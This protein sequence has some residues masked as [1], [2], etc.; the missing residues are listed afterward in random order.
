MFFFL[1]ASFRIRQSSFL[2]GKFDL[3]DES[4]V[5]V[6]LWETE[7]VGIDGDEVEMLESLVRHHVCL[8][9]K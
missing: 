9:A 8:S 4:I 3:T 5:Y 7:E 6:A 1:F 2:G